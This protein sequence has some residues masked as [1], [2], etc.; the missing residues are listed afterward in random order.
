MFAICPK[1]EPFGDAEIFSNEQ[2]AYEEAMSWSVELHG[3][4][5]L[6]YEWSEQIYNWMPR[7]AVNA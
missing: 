1:S 2:D 7:S 6:L 4:T 5:V 3:A